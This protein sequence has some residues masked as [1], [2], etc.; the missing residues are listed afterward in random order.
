MNVV[1]SEAS[2]V[3]EVVSDA[4]VSH[5]VQRVIPRMIEGYHGSCAHSREC[6]HGLA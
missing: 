3:A 4:V 5:E 1:V 6:S 2:F